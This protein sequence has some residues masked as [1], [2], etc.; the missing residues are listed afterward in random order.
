[1]D[2]R[3]APA[4]NAASSDV[5]VIACETKAQ[6]FTLFR[7]AYKDAI[8]DN[9]SRFGFK[10]HRV[11]LWIV[12]GR[13]PNKILPH[14]EPE[15]AAWDTVLKWQQTISDQST[16]DTSGLAEVVL[17]EFA[18]RLNVTRFVLVVPADADAPPRESWPGA[19]GRRRAGGGGGPLC[20]REECGQPG[21]RSA[22]VAA[23]SPHAPARAAAGGR[24]GGAA[25]HGTEIDPRPT[26]P[27]G[28]PLLQPHCK[29]TR[30]RRAK[31][32]TGPR[33]GTRPGS[34]RRSRHRRPSCRK[35]IRSS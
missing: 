20:P 27:P 25:T 6:K 2:R 29:T 32:K 12:Q 5:I 26:T 13:E 1:M 10:R 22:R 30:R 23:C 11:G 34:R 33:S 19:A 4:G 8:H 17:K 15:K 28:K 7:R 18:S 16:V 31:E 35:R 3:H 14:D 24:G 21:S 9:P